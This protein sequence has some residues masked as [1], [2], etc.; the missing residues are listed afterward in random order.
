MSDE[1]EGLIYTGIPSKEELEASP[2]YPPP[3]VL[4]KGPT[5]VIECVQDIPC[6]PCEAACPK[7]AILVGE[8]ITNLPR[9]FPE[10]CDACGLCIPACPGQA[11]F[12]IDMTYSEKEAAV[13]FPYEFLPMPEKGNVVQAVNRAGEVVCEGKVLRVLTPRKYDRTA[14]ITLAVPKE[15]AMEVRSMRRL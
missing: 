9:F 11:I 7:G 12:R 4:A 6:N 10:R 3:E 14:V 13:S 2:G 1:K 8:P 15:L 5:V